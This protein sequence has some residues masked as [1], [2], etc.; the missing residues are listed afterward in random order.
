MDSWGRWNTLGLPLRQISGLSVGARSFHFNDDFYFSNPSTGQQVSA[1]LLFSKA[2][3][4]S[5][6][7]QSPRLIGTSNLCLE[8]ISCAKHNLYFQ[9]WNWKFLPLGAWGMSKHEI[10]Y[11][12]KSV[13][14]LC[15]RRDQQ[16]IKKFDENKSFWS[17]ARFHVASTVLPCK[18]DTTNKPNC[19]IEGINSFKK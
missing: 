16:L 7:F 10:R 9:S 8:N 4:S 6:I 12:H 19:C 17:S 1:A 5:D 11:E 3:P 15:W 2:V 13:A 18:T 14:D